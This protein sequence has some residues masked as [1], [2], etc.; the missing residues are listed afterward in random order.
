MA[1]ALSD[2]REH[3]RANTGVTS[4]QVPDADLNRFINQAILRYRGDC[5]NVVA[6]ESLT[7]ATNTFEY[8]L[9]G[10]T[11]LSSLYS[12]HLLEG[13]DLTENGRYETVIPYAY[14]SLEA[15]SPPFIRFRSDLWSPQNGR[16]IRVHGQVRQAQLTSD[17][18]SLDV[19]DPTLVIL[20]AEALLWR[21]VSLAQGDLG[22]LGRTN[23]TIAEA[24][25]EQYRR[26][27]SSDRRL[28]PLARR[29]PGREL[30]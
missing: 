30:V 27:L 9:S 6:D 8:P 24:S 21:R 10:G 3:V 4:R 14:W 22:V 28:L 29:I 25:A 11:Y 2:L 23:A 19:L 18:S 5:Y 12:I 13:E 17:Q 1:L 7:Q 20:Y 15:G 16:H 26:N